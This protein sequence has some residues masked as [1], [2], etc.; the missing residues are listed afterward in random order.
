MLTPHSTEALDYLTRT[1]YT[2]PA[3]GDARAMR[4][5]H[6]VETCGRERWYCERQRRWWCTGDTMRGT[7]TE[8]A[9]RIEACADAVEEDP[10]MMHRDAEGAREIVRAMREDAKILRACAVGTI[11][12]QGAL[13]A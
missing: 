10:G 9:K 5:T 4:I 11:D 7:L 12:A 8:A 13:F 6:E 1:I 3:I 2:I